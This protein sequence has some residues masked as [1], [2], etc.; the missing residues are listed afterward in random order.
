MRPPRAVSYNAVVMI[1]VIDNYDSF[2]HNLSRYLRRLGQVTEV[3]RN[4]AITCE[5]LGRRKPDA[6]VLSPG[7]CT[8]N[9]AGI[10]L[11]VVRRFIGK[12]PLLGVCLGHQTIAAALGGVIVR[13]PEPMHG[14]ASLIYHEG[15]VLFDQIPSP[16]RAGR[17]HSLIADSERLPPSIAPIAWTEDGLVM[18][19]RHEREPVWG[20][21][22]HPESIL[23]DYGY[24][25]LGNFLRAAGLSVPVDIDP[26]SEQELARDVRR[27]PLATPIT[28]VP[29]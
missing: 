25:L 6:I 20:V 24:R 4:D 2:V 18:A 23:T 8:P 27:V 13:S 28:P 11:E 1:V 22:F 15:D 5:E 12:V 9:E 17:Y 7:P 14:R 3:V 21:Q 26:L 10:S 29:Y 16:F 19:I